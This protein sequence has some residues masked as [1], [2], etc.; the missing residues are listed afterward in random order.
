MSLVDSL[1]G[2]TESARQLFSW[3][4]REGSRDSYLPITFSSLRLLHRVPLWE[5]EDIDAAFSRPRDVLAELEGYLAANSKDLAVRWTVLALLYDLSQEPEDGENDWELP[6][7][8]ESDRALFREELRDL[9]SLSNIGDLTDPKRVRW[10]TQNSCLVSD[11]Q[12]A[13]KLFRRLQEVEPENDAFNYALLGEFHLLIALRASPE[14]V[15]VSA[16]RL[17]PGLA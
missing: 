16:G 5:E 15:G 14:D 8:D 11:F 13:E 9:V 3:F 6:G 17:A 10:E 4:D 7:R 2:W 1:D 12:R